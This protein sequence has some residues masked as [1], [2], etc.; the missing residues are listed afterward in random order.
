MKLTNLGWILAAG[1]GAALCASGF[2]TPP[3]KVGIVNLQTVFQTSELFS[4]KQNDLKVMG[5]GRSD[6]LAFIQTYPTI[7]AVQ[8]QR[9][10]DLSLKTTELTGP[11]KTELEKIKAAVMADDKALKALQTK[12]NPTPAEVAK[13]GAYQQQTQ[14]TQNLLQ[15]WAQEFKLQISDQEGKYRDE[16]LGKA[17]SA[18]RDVGKKQ[19]FSL[20]FSSDV[21]PFASNDVTPDTLK[22]MNAKK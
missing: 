17:T 5:E 11:E 16:V 19:G 15:T 1:M 4:L 2:Q 13:M 9:F 14:Q 8:A 3:T 6:I 18:T 21:A 12:T 7:T 10:R 22:V 20:I